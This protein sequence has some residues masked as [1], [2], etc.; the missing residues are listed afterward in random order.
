MDDPADH[1]E[2]LNRLEEVVSLAS[3]LCPF[4]SDKDVFK[5]LEGPQT[6][7][8]GWVKT[9]KTREYE[10]RKLVELADMEVSAE[11]RSS[12]PRLL[13]PLSYAAA[14]PLRGTDQAAELVTALRTPHH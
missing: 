8:T 5:R 2:S 6:Q 12:A 10:D 14:V 1:T 9:M 3:P 13:T 11:Q 4:M 7:G